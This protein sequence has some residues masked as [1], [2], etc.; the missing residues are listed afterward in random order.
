MTSDETEI[1]KGRLFY[2][3]RDH[4]YSMSCVLCKVLTRQI[5]NNSQC[6]RY[7]QLPLFFLKRTTVLN[8]HYL[9][10]TKKKGKHRIKFVV[11]VSVAEKIDFENIQ[12]ARFIKSPLLSRCTDLCGSPLCLHVKRAR[13]FSCSMAFIFL[14]KSI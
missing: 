1:V 4:V 12:G 11:R 13:L 8:A 14:I 5:H 10:I 2:F 7:V 3:S 9:Y 6:E